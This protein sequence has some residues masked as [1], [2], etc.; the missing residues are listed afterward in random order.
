VGVGPILSG[1]NGEV[2]YF[3]HT[4][5]L[6]ASWSHHGATKSPRVGTTV[7]RL[8]FSP[9]SINEFWVNFAAPTHIALPTRSGRRRVYE[10]IECDL[11]AGKAVLRT[12][13]C[14]IE[15]RR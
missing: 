5:A 11:K 3:G 4:V 10:L 14:A 7:A 9:K 13:P 8:T 2:R 15:E 12:P 1:R 6:L